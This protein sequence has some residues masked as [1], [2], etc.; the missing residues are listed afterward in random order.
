MSETPSPSTKVEFIGSVT[1]ST[2]KVER[3]R[4]ILFGV[5]MREYTQKL[6]VVQH[7]VTRLQQET[8]RLHDQLQE[9]EKNF[10]C[11]MREENDR[12]SAQLQEQG[13]Q[14]SQL[15][16]EAERR[17]TQ[18]RQDVDQRHRQHVQQLG[19]QIQ[20]SEYTVLDQLSQLAS[21]L[22]YAKVD[23]S[24]LGELLIDL[25]TNLKANA[26][27]PLTKVPGLLDQLSEE[28]R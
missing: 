9:Q 11:Q 25:G 3:I 5:Q 28:L 8:G 17:Q 19:E 20:H 1:E 6:D 18:Q 14:Q 26:A 24:T 12:L 15:L 16:Q 27:D 4:E 2:E 21:R 10:R 23:R 13:A 22:N 7:E